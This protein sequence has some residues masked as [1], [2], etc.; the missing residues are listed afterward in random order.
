MCKGT[1]MLMGLERSRNIGKLDTEHRVLG[2][3]YQELQLE[4]CFGA[5]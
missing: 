3:K 4:A 5:S 2:R 1:K